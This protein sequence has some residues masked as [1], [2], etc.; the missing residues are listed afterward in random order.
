M[1]ILQKVVFRHKWRPA[2]AFITKF[3]IFGALHVFSFTN[4]NCCNELLTYVCVSIV[5]HRTNAITNV[6]KLLIKP[7][8]I[9]HLRGARLTLISATM[10]PLFQNA[11]TSIHFQS[12]LSNRNNWFS[13]L[14]HKW[15]TL[16]IRQFVSKSKFQDPH[17]HLS[18]IGNSLKHK[19]ELAKMWKEEAGNEIM[20]GVRVSYLSQ[21]ERHW[22]CKLS[23]TRNELPICEKSDCSILFD[24]ALL[25]SLKKMSALLLLLLWA[26][27]NRETISLQKKKKEKEG[28]SISVPFR[29][30]H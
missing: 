13:P 10:E 20:N 8:H 21:A 1:M 18:K 16:V 5:A 26:F 28:V 7:D 9:S 17:Q 15:K 24:L 22:G 4:E 6:C 23:A 14:L 19:K 30:Q 11:T 2:G 29:E 27:I 25:S 12:P 3:Q